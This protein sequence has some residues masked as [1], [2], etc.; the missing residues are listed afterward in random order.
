LSSPVSFMSICLLLQLLALTS[1]IHSINS[2]SKVH[3]RTLS[4]YDG[5]KMQSIIRQVI[6]IAFFKQSV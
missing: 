4:I 5:I 6:F 1:S 3:S 2:T